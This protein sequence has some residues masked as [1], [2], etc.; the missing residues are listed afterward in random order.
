M[1]KLNRRNF[2]KAGGA[3]VAA[4]GFMAYAPL[5]F[6]ASKK[7]VIVGGGMAGT[8]A[9]K[10][11]RMMDDSVEVTLIEANPDYYTCFMS[12][13]VITG[14]RDI[15]NIKF[16]YDGVKGHGVNVVIDK[17]TGIDAEKKVVM[18]AGGTKH[19]YDRCIVAPGISFKW[20][21]IEGYD[22]KVAETITHAWKAGPQT[23][24]LQNQLKDMKDGGTVVIGTPPNPFRCPP[25]PYER[26]SLIADY[27]QTHKP[28]SKIIVLD[29]KDKFSKFGWFMSAWKRHYGYGTDN[30][31][32]EWIKGSDGGV[33]TSVDAATN[34]VEAVAGSFKGDVVNIIPPQKAGT[35]ADVVGL[36]N[37]DG[38]CPVEGKTFESTLHANI[39]VVGDAAL[40]SPMPKSGYAASSQGKVAAAAVVALLNGEDA[41]HP[42]YVNTCYSVVKPGEGISVAAVYGYGEGKIFKVKGAGGLTPNDEIDLDSR[43]REEKYGH[44]WFNNITADTFG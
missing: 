7:V 23:V 40:A 1:N 3:A 24:T 37:A 32:I 8:T 27:L 33:I 18:T 36:S 17:V 5:S 31:M 38:W 12:N 42:T 21:T 25:G 16:G 2:L 34:T 9:A 39:H 14:H 20:D 11:I 19:S 29:P 28:K 30:S 10:Y 13:E 26:I 4:T 43:A 44:S 41:P 35:I 22:E 15:N 6:G